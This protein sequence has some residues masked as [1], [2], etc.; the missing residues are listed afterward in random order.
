MQGMD[1][2]FLIAALTAEITSVDKAVRLLPAG[3]FRAVDGR[4]FDCEAWVLTEALAQQ[5]ISQAAARKTRIVVD[6][7][8]QTLNTV[9]NG[10]KAPAAGWIDPASLQWRDDG[11]YAEIEWTAAARAHIEAKEYLY[12]SPVFIYIETGEI[13]DL[14]HIALTNNPAL[15]DQK[16]LLAYLSFNFNPLYQP[17]KEIP[18]D[19]TL[20][21]QL[22]WL[23][24]LSA[25]TA[26]EVLQAALSSLIE[27][28]SDGK[29]IAAAS[30]DLPA[31][32]EEKEQRITALTAAETT[33]DPAKYVPIDTVKSMQQQIASLS[34]QVAGREVDELLTA[35]LS[36]GR[37]LPAQENWAR[38]LGQSNITALKDYLSTVTPV[39][40]LTGTQTGGKSPVINSAGQLTAEEL[41]VCAALGQNPDTFKG[42]A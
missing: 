20:K 16:E 32:L 42:K 22:C 8:H 35:A 21:A 26:D 31:L 23:F 27:K 40:A 2:T 39:A 25:D 3:R 9:Q 28:L 36:D 38:T 6:Y 12:L 30:V 10:Q 1:K 29:G 14:L 15:G 33:V 17:K 19:K 34:A 5:I 37:L 4:P 11:L 41:A 24:N 13:T 7:E 18:M